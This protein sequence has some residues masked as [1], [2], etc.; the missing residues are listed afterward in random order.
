MKTK[1]TP[2]TIEHVEQIIDM[3]LF[4]GTEIEE[5]FFDLSKW[6]T[7]GP[8][9]VFMID[10]QIAYAI[11]FFFGENENEETAM[12]WQVPTALFYKHK[13]TCYSATIWM[14]NWMKQTY[15]IVMFKTWIRDDKK[16]NKNWV[17]HLGFDPTL[18]G[19]NNGRVFVVYEG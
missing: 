10:D 4:S 19:T 13:K 9:W 7:R 2:M 6:F 14:K 11:G 1:F 16:R 8:S 15:H 17:E 12:I 3:N 5:N 18:I